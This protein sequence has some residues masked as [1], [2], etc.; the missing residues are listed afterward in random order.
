[1]ASRALLR[2]LLALLIAASLAEPYGEYDYGYGYDFYSNDED[3]E[4]SA[5]P[6]VAPKP[7]VARTTFGI[8]QHDS[9]AQ[10]GP[11]KRNA[12]PLSGRMPDT[13]A[14]VQLGGR[15]P[16]PASACA[17]QLTRVSLYGCVCSQ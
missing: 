4:C 9:S 8:S 6:R 2:A 14:A 5:Q 15:Q 1:M 7:T 13:G 12:E 17:Q 16:R 10:Q 3:C 11:A